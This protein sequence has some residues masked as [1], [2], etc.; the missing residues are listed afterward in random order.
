[1]NEDNE[2]AEQ[3]LRMEANNAERH[4]R[5]EYER[6]AEE[7]VKGAAEEAR[8][9]KEAQKKKRGENEEA[10]KCERKEY[11]RQAEEQVKGAA[12]E[13]RELKEAQKKKRGEDKETRETTQGTESEIYK[14]DV[15]IVVSYM[16]D[17][18]QTT[19]FKESL[20]QLENIKIMWSGGSSEETSITVVSVQKPMPLIR[21]LNEMPMVERVYR[22]GEKIVVVLKASSVS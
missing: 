18:R 22:R 21:T 9:L 16:D 12:E 20:G 13:A 8:E 7:Q 11:E 4:R 3:R 2:K 1:M 17:Y 19:Q 14:G 15:Q 5:K 6:Q 10:R